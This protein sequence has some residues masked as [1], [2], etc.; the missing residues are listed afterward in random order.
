[1]DCAQSVSAFVQETRDKV[2]VI[3]IKLQRLLDGYLD[4]I[5]EQDIYKV[6]K[7][8][9]VSQKKSLEENLITLEQTQTG[10]IEPMSKWIIKAE[11]LPKI[12]EC[13]DLLSKKVVSKEIFGSNLLLFGQTISGEPNLPWNLVLNA[14][15]SV[16]N[17]EN[18]DECAIL[19]RVEGIGP[20]PKDW[21]SLV[22]P[23]NY[24]RSLSILTN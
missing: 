7:N 21:K 2:S 5:I 20:S 23:L 13:D 19:E 1:M 3:N 18:F 10:W 15:N 8:K 17:G 9:L 6:E 14:K 24:T 22:L 12:A 11:N 16:K 4:Q